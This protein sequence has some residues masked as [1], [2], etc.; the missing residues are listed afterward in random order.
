VA[1]G[2]L[3]HR[4]RNI[5]GV[6]LEVGQGKRGPDWAREV[7]QGRDRTLGGVTAP[8]NGLTLMAVEYPA[9]FAVP[10]SRDALF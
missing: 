8:A 6:L 4:V 3:H 2:F 9:E 5:A 7:L 1:D 10:V